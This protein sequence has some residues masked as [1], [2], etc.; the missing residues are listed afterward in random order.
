MREM[1]LHRPLRDEQPLG[2]LTVRPTL[3]GE[4]GDADFARRQR[5]DAREHGPAGPPARGDEFIAGPPRERGRAGAMGKFEA[6]PERVAGLH[7]A[8]VP[9]DSGT[10]LDQCPGKI[11]PSRGLLEQFDRRAQERQAVCA[12]RDGAGHPG[13]R[14]EYP[15]QPGRPRQ[16]ELL[17]RES[18]SLVLLAD[19]R[20]GQRGVLTPSYDPCADAPQVVPAAAGL[21]Q[22]GDALTA[23]CPARRADDR[24][25][26]P[27]T[28]RRASRAASSCRSTPCQVPR[29][30]PSG[31]PAR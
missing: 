30:P 9:A 12:R 25:P 8:A 21:E 27:G 16:L 29:R 14:P 15:R 6:P 3:G 18:S 5:F 20:E 24:E 13:R 10:Q 19:L 22:V 28:P 2:G 1:C 11:E 7:R 31:R 17:G 26:R 4:S 23:S